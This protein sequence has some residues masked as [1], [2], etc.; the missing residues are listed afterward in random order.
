MPVDFHQAYLFEVL[1]NKESNMSSWKKASKTN[2]KT[3]RERHQPEARAHLGLLEKKKDYKKRSNDYHRKQKILKILRKKALNKNPDE[4]YFHM[5]NSKMLASGHKEKIKPDTHT[6]E[7]LKIM[8]T[9][10]LKYVNYKRTIEHK[11]IDKMQSTLHLLD[12]ANQVRNNHTFFVESTDEVKNFNLAA[13]LDTHP[14]LL[15]RKTNRIR[16]SD[17]QNLNL[18]D[19]SSEAL[20]EKKKV[21]NELEK[22]LN[23]E[24]ELSII[25]QKLEIKKF[26]KDKTAKKPKQIKPGT[27]DAPP[28]YKWE[29]KRKK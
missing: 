24:K 15:N 10:D 17:L 1:N 7:Q 9:K 14:S 4:F 16:N 19:V 18:P 8:E 3:H 11:K 28:V 2:Q 13:R 6:P 21:Y 5:I 26:L 23:R 29:Y 12:S 22:R 20:Q 25:Q 27:K